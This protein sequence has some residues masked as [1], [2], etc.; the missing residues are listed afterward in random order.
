MAQNSRVRALLRAQRGRGRA[1][2]GLG[3]DEAAAGD[4]GGALQGEM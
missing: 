4:T 2:L 3:G 1:R